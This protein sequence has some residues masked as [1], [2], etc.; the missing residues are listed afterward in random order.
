MVEI[1]R[2]RFIDLGGNNWPLRSLP[3]EA[4]AEVGSAT[5]NMD[6]YVLK[7]SILRTGDTQV[8]YEKA[9]GPLTNHN[10]NEILQ[11]MRQNH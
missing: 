5:H 1:F 4:I 2:S 9:F 7:F 11:D 10:L 8:A 3:R 6:L